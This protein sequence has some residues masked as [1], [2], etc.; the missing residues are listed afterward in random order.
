MNHTLLSVAVAALCFAGCGPLDPLHPQKCGGPSATASLSAV[1]LANDCGT[2][3]E[4]AAPKADFAAGACLAGTPCP[5]LCR[6]SSMQLQFSAFGDAKVE[7]HDVRMIDPSTGQV[8]Q[9]LKS[10]EPQQWSADKYT[11]WDEVVPAGVMV[12]AS[13]KLSAPT[14]SYGAADARFGYQSAYKIEVDLSIGG[15]LRTLQG[16]AT[17]EPEVAT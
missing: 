1:T 5:S 15:E 16:E 9:H 7:I 14:Y 8:L 11:A 12:R 10:R 4:A 17:R 3:T 2:A 6:Q 13:Y